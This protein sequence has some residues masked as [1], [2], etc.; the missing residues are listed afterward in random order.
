M[1]QRCLCASVWDGP[2]TLSWSPRVPLRLAAAFQGNRA[3]QRPFPSIFH[4]SRQRNRV[5][6]LHELPARCDLYSNQWPDFRDV[7]KRST[8]N[9]NDRNLGWGESREDQGWWRTHLSTG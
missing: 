5:F 2:K 4:R 9:R 7:G 1:Y 8:C 6:L 3:E